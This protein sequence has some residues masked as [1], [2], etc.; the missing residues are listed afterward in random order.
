MPK[1]VRD[2]KKEF[3]FI[4]GELR[5]EEIPKEYI[6]LRKSLLAF[7]VNVR[8]LLMERIPQDILEGG[9]YTEA[10]NKIVAFYRFFEGYIGQ[11]K[12]R[13]DARQEA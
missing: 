10:F 2:A 3:A 1:V 9:D 13:L 8:E 5:T 6:R 4:D 11:L 7:D 12:S